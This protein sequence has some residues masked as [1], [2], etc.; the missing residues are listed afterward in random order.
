[1]FVYLVKKLAPKQTIHL[2]CK[3]AIIYQF[4]ELFV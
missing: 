3:D 1:M 2:F 4:K